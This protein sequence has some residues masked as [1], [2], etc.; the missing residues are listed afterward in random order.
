MEPNFVIVPKPDLL[1]LLWSAFPEFKSG[2]DEE[3]R[4][5]GNYY[6]YARFADWLSAGREDYRLWQ[7]A[8]RFFELL[9][10]VEPDMVVDVLEF[11]CQDSILAQR[12]DSNAGPEV[13]KL[14]RAMRG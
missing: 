6:V 2:V 14:R 10:P 9:A 12:I 4:D 3:D 11:L 13:C 8:C 1:S 5:L 7:R